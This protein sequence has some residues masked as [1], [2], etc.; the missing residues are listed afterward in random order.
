MKVILMRHGEAAEG[1]TPDSAR[2]LTDFGIK[3][4]KQT[5]GYLA[6]TYQ[7][8]VL[9]ASPFDRAQQTMAQAAKHF[10][11]L[12]VITQD[13]LTPSDDPKAAFLQLAKIEAD[14]LLV[15]CHMSIVA[16]LASLLTG[17][18]FEAFSL[19]EARVFEMEFLMTGMAREIDRFVPDQP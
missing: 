14:C 3:Q 7:L 1:V 10:P 13:N 8:D 2:P 18:S 11:T 19:A 4:A 5:A 9:V 6:D 15:V 12:S 16:K 17:D